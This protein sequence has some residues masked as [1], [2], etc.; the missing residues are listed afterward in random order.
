LKI[1][2]TGINADIAAAPR[3]ATNPD[4]GVDAD[5]NIPSGYLPDA[6]LVSYIGLHPM[7]DK[8]SQG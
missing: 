4:V 7:P 2:R 8:P 6:P 5:V 1:D 3:Q